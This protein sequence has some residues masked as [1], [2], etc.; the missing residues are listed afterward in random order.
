M[1][2]TARTPP[3]GRATVTDDPLSLA[4]MRVN[5]TVPVPLEVGA[6]AGLRAAAAF[7]GR[8][9]IDV[10]DHEGSRFLMLGWPDDFDQGAIFG[11]ESWTARQVPPG[12]QLFLAAC[13]RCCWPS[14][15]QSLYPGDPAPEE[16]VMA[17]LERFSQASS[18]TEAQRQGVHS[19]GKRAL[20]F[21]RACG[22]LAP[23]TGDAQIRLGP[24]IAA[25][26]EADIR[27]LRDRFDD[28]PGAEE[29][30]G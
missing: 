4:R 11:Q 2:S 26:N 7:A 17:A 21:L 24:E 27:P 1:A 16:R 8:Q 5:R 3:E 20:R 6:L 29:A 12:A 14:P 30:T 25:W 15:D 23:D 22:F 10:Q 19:A 18:S 13:I 28:L 9:L